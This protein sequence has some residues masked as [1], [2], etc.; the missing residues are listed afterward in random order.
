MKNTNEKVKFYLIQKVN[1]SLPEYIRATKN[2]KIGRIYTLEDGNQAKV[3]R[4]AHFKY[5]LDDIQ[6]LADMLVGGYKGTQQYRMYLKMNSIKR[7]QIPRV[8]FS[9]IEKELIYYIYT[10]NEYNTDE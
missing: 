10:N 7:S 9:E 2:L 4:Q 1:C 5:S 8:R 3:L 6:N